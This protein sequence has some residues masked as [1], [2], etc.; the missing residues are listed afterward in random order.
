MFYGLF[1]QGNRNAG[2][3]VF[4]VF[5]IFIAYLFPCMRQAAV[6]R[7]SKRRSFSRTKVDFKTY[8]D[9]PIAKWERGGCIS[10]CARKE[11]P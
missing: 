7:A 9:L 4:V 5:L 3:A 6:S 2:E 8:F 1:A 11:R 10:F